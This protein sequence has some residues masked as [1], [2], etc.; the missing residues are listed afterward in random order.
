V[1]LANDIK[2]HWL[3][4]R[5]FSPGYPSLEERQEPFDFIVAELSQWES[6]LPHRLRPLKDSSKINGMILLAFAKV[7]DEKLAG[8]CPWIP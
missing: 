4:G 6:Q 8:D 5:Y 1:Q 2:A 3:N 7:L